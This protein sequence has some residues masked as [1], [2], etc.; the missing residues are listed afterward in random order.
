MEGGFEPAGF[1]ARSQKQTCRAGLIPLEFEPNH[2]SNVV[3]GSFVV[4]NN[5][6]GNFRFSI[7]VV[8]FSL[9]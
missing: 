3:L 2:C 5:V 9:E 6:L 8:G 4:S 7:E 1:L